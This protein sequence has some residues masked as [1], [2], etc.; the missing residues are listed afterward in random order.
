MKTFIRSI[1][2][3]F[4]FLGYALAHGPTPQKLEESIEINAPPE[5][6]WALVK[7]FDGIAK[8]HPMLASAKGQNGKN[9]NGAER[10]LTFKTGGAITES[11]DEYDADRRFYGY[12][13]LKEN[14]K[15][16]PVSSHSSRLEVKDSGKGG[17]LVEW[18]GRF[19]RGDTGNEPHAN[20]NDEAATKAMSEFA[21]SGLENLKRLA[22]GGQ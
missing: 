22:E 13:M 2:I 6:V 14:P 9:A 7:D 20:L 15:A 4:L 10:V 1:A 3:Y 18:I 21:K 16:F 11:L 8:W 5:K 17:S 12:R 19:Y